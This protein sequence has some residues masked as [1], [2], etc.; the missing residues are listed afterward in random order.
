MKNLVLLLLTLT[1]VTL[2]GCNRAGSNTSAP[3]YPGLEHV[4][5]HDLRHTAVTVMAEA[6]L[7]EHVIM[8]QVGH[9]SPQMLKTYSH[10]RRLALNTA[11]AALEPSHVSP[12]W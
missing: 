2:T 10:V 6:G 1:L 8:A 7:P 4:R 11:A 3:I 9:I 5:F 12:K